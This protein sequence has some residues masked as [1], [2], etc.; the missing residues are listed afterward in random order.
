METRCIQ[1]IETDEIGMETM[2]KQSQKIQTLLASF[3]TLHCC[4]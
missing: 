3:L 4:L 1:L 2:P